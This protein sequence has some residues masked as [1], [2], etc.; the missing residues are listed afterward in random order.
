[1]ATQA[2]SAP[3]AIGHSRGFVFRAVLRGSKKFHVRR[4]QITDSRHQRRGISPDYPPLRHNSRGRYLA[5]RRCRT[6]IVS[7]YLEPDNILSFIRSL[8]PS[9]MPGHLLL[10]NIIY[11]CICSQ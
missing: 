8:T 7:G 5:Y 9:I 4:L 10:C 6:I 2:L 3:L 11:D 1:M